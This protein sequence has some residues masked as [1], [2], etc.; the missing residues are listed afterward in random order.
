MN[1]NTLNDVI[2]GLRLIYSVQPDAD[3]AAEHEEIY[4]GDAEHFSDIH[5]ALLKGWGWE[6]TDSG[7]FRRYV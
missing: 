2:E 6:P 5:L 1:T 7:N 4:C 3:I